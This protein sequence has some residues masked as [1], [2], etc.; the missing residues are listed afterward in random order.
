[1]LMEVTGVYFSIV[2]KMSGTSFI[3]DGYFTDNI[4][5]PPLLMAVGLFHIFIDVKNITIINSAV[6]KYITQCIQILATLSYGVYLTHEFISQSLADIFGWSIDS[7]HI[8]IYLYNGLYFA[9]TL[10]GSMAITFII[11]RIPKLRIIIRSAL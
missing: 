3:F 4:A 5:I 9:I 11:S 2:H 8:N 7:I 1:M 10:F 6:S